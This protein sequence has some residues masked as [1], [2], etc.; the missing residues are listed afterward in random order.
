MSLDNNQQRTHRQHKKKYTDH[1]QGKFVIVRYIFSVMILIQMKQI[2]GLSIYWNT[3]CQS[4]LGLSFDEV[5]VS[6]FHDR[7][8]MIDSYEEHLFSG[9]FEE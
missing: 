7:T 2:N 4:R 6:L 3:K 5:V 8:K 9:R 1:F